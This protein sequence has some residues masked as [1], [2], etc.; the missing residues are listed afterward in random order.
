MPEAL[1]CECGARVHRE[2]A[3]QAETYGGLDPEKW[4][5]LCCPNC[6]RQ[7]KTVYVGDAGSE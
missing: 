7:L 1:D 3:R 5:T 6:G 4:Q 2:D